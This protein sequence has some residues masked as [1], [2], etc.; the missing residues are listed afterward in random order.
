MERV[1]DVSVLPVAMKMPRRRRGRRRGGRCHPN[2]S[3]DSDSVRLAS[4]MAALSVDMSSMLPSSE[5]LASMFPG[6]VADFWRPSDPQSALS[7][8]EEEKAGV[9]LSVASES[10]IVADVLVVDCG[11]CWTGVQ[12]D[13]SCLVP[14]CGHVLCA[15]CTRRWTRAQHQLAPAGSKN[16]V[17]LTCPTCRAVVS[18]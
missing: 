3:V 12:V 17:R 5:L 14:A 6:A 18:S 15:P 4:L 8:D 13:A 9:S 11:V 10:A 2:R 16:S 1:I 7:D